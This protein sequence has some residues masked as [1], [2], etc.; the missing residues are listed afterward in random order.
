M[1]PTLLTSQTI[2]STS[3]LQEQIRL[4]AYELYE[5]RG[6]EDGRDLDDWL[7]AESE[8]TGQKPTAIAA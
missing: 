3:D 1:K 7:Q 5:Q 2:E 6:R 8:V 4:R